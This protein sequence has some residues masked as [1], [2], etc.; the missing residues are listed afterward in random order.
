MME[1]PKVASLILKSETLQKIQNRM[2]AGEQ[3]VPC[4]AASLRALLCSDQQIEVKFPLIRPGRFF[5]F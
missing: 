4:C 3:E 1:T 2:R 5:F